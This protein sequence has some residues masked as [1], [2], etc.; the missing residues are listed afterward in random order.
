MAVGIAMAGSCGD[1]ESMALLEPMLL[2]RTDY[3]RQGALM[4]N[5][6]DLHAAE[7]QRQWTQDSHLSREIVDH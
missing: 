2:D 4:G 3:V 1:P 7:R 5:S 6:H